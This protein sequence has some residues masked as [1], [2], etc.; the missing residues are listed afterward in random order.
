MRLSG[1][2]GKAPFGFQLAAGQAAHCFSRW[3]FWGSVGRRAVSKMVFL[4]LEV[5]LDAS[6]CV[7]CW[8]FILWMAACR[9][10]G[11][12]SGDAAGCERLP[13]EVGSLEVLM[14]EP[15]EGCSGEDA[16]KDPWWGA[17]GWASGRFWL[18]FCPSCWSVYHQSSFL[19]LLVVV[20]LWFFFFFFLEMHHPIWTGVL[21]VFV[22]VP[23]PVFL[24]TACDPSEFWTLEFGKWVPLQWEGLNHRASL[25]LPHHL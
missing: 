17:L 2:K 3:V 15:W 10:G 19:S 6:V 13:T 11:A 20:W 4:R 14:S 18:W 16:L 22:G 23:S 8:G 25:S 21:H 5:C 24:M 7:F 12:A 1:R 9:Q